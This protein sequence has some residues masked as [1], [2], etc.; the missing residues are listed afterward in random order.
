MPSRGIDVSNNQGQIDWAAVAGSGVEFAIAKAAEGTG[1][2]DRFFAGNW[3]AMK[4]NGLVRG[5]YHFSRPSSTGAVAEAEFFLAC[6]NHAGGLE[7]GD[8]VVLDLED[9]DSG[10]D[11]SGW[12]LQWLQHVHA[13]VG[14]KPILYSGRYYLQD[15]GVAVPA[16]AEYPLWLAA[17][18]TD[19]PANVPPWPTYLIW[20]Y[21][22]S[23]S[24]PGVAGDCD[25]D[26]VYDLNELRAY[27][28]P[29]DVPP[30]QPDE[31]PYVVGEGI[32]AKMAARSDS[33][34]SSEVY[35]G[36]DGQFSE[37]MGQSGCIYRYVKLTGLVYV[38][39]PAA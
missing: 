36:M 17:Y 4:A 39:E 26:T 10:G 15:H 8:L 6:L 16:I 28:M 31:T 21:S 23:G 22:S 27:G 9:P 30:H 19:M 18:Q 12:T 29:G 14:F 37:A 33:P 3:A 32:L 7:P 5:A 24:V 11:L 34:A 2:L 35:Q 20:Q 13:A 25:M 38:F 1:F